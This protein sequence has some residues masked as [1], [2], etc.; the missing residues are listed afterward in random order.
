MIKI[1]TILFLLGLGNSLSALPATNDANIMWEN[2]IANKTFK[3]NWN[4]AKHYCKELEHVGFSD[5]SLP[6]KK[7]LLKI[8]EEKDN[9]ELNTNNLYWSSNE[10]KVTSKYA[11]R[12]DLGDKDSYHSHRSNT[13]HVRCVRTN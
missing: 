11:W 10:Y 13:Y 8:Q 4:D 1:T 6:N 5:W 2:S 9:L 7:Q 3:L 12:V